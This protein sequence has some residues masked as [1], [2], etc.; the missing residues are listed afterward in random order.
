MPMRLRPHYAEIDRRLQHARQAL[1]AIARSSISRQQKA[2][3]AQ[4]R[5]FIAQAEEMRKT[6]VAGAR[7][8]AERADV[9][10]TDLLSSL[11]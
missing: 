5:D 1:A 9:L 4:I 6:N 3:V 2:T 11:K 10:A 7:S 8:L